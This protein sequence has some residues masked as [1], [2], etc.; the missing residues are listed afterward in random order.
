MSD[1]ATIL[2][3]RLGVKT[4][5]VS[6]GWFSSESRAVLDGERGDGEVLCAVEIDG[7]KPRRVAAGVD[8]A[9]ADGE[10]PAKDDMLFAVR[11]TPFGFDMSIPAGRDSD[12]F[13]WFFEVGGMLEITK[14]EAFAA[15][16]RGDVEKDKPLMAEA[17]EKA[18]G[19]IPST[20]LHDKLTVEVLGVMSLEDKDAGEQYADIRKSLEAWRSANEAF[21]ASATNDAFKTFFNADGVARLD[22]SSFH[23]RSPQRE[24]ADKK[25]QM[26]KLAELNAR[27]AALK[28]PR[29]E[30]KMKAAAH[31][32][33]IHSRDLFPETSSTFAE[34]TPAGFGPQ[35][36]DPE[37]QD[38]RLSIGDI[39]TLE[40]SSNIDGWLHLY[41]YGTSGKVIQLAPGAYSSLDNGRIHAGRTYV[42]GNGGDLIT[43]PLRENGPTTAQGGHTERFIAIITKYPVDISA[44]SVKAVF[45]RRNPGK[46]FASRGGF[47]AVEEIHHP[48]DE[49]P[50]EVAMASLL[51]LPP[52][53][54]VQGTLEL[55]VV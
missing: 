42:A 32:N 20:I 35:A 54:W 16:F 47:G 5:K 45:D 8:G 37:R 25:R 4:K 1:K 2:M 9:F 28:G 38:N 51:D 22:G 39:V 12:G 55:E 40:L 14:P 18:L 29:P 17:F 6:K 7:A 19:T 53:D 31:R 46:G 52:E 44:E 11:R 49:E 36:T 10:A 30:I 33:G 41:N 3:R 21:V 15:K 26:L 13:E 34:G 24:E 43:V 27:I 23:A 50:L 48:D